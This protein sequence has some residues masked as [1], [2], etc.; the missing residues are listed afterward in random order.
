M[1]PLDRAR[2]PMCTHALSVG[3]VH[4]LEIA[5]VKQKDVHVDY[6]LQVRICGRQQD[7]H[8]FQDLTCLGSYIR[9]S[10]FAGLGIGLSNT[11]ALTRHEFDSPTT[12]DTISFSWQ[13]VTTMDAAQGTINQ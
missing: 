5:H 1:Y 4:F 11:S 9:S 12:Q 6:V 7:R 10:D 2:R 8:V 3:A 13:S